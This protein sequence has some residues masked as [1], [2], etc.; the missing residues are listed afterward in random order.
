MDFEPIPSLDYRYEIDQHG[1]VRNA[2]T[3]KVLK[4]RTVKGVRTSSL[5]I[6]IN[7][8]KTTYS[9]PSLLWEVHGKL[10]NPTIPIGVT[11][12]KGGEVHYFPSLYKCSIW[13]EPRLHLKRRSIQNGYLYLRRSEIAGWKITYHE[14]EQ[15]V[16]KI[17][18]SNHKSKRRE[19]K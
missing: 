4:P 2:E 12:S 19:I 1:T 5:S 10:S 15:R 9:I 8:K 13:L 11:I 18:H 16:F 7:G 6:K 3:K 14:P 17:R